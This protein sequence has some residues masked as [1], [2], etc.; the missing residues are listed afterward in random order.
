MKHRDDI[1]GW[2]ID[3]Q[4]KK[5]PNNNWLQPDMNYWVATIQNSASYHKKATTPNQI[6][7]FLRSLSKQSHFK[8]SYFKK[9][10]AWNCVKRMNP[11]EW[12]QQRWKLLW[13]SY[14]VAFRL[15]G[16]QEHPNL[17]LTSQVIAAMQGFIKQNRELNGVWSQGVIDPSLL[18]SPPTSSLTPSLSPCK[19]HCCKAW[20]IQWFPWF[21]QPAE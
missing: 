12:L 11:L 3:S 9:A 19:A 2:K 15:V 20:T 4:E 16:H 14:M 18:S 1:I 5:D 8:K 21:H 7:C 17:Q 13:I 10:N 6:G